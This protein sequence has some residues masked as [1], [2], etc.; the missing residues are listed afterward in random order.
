MK[1]SCTMALAAQGNEI[2]PQP[3]PRTLQPSFSC[4]IDYLKP[5][6]GFTRDLR[7]RR[8]G[9]GGVSILLSLSGGQR[10]FRASCA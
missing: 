7:D 1:F 8:R 5:F 4:D 9:R 6:N 10:H 2:H 3:I